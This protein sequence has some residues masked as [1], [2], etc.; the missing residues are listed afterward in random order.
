MKKFLILFG[1]LIFSTD[2]TLSQSI[3]NFKIS[4][5]TIEWQL[6]YSTDMTFDELYQEIS[7]LGIFEEINLNSE[8]CL[9][10][11]LAKF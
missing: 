10:M 4:N 11:Q 6:V 2:V 7:T 5:S 8:V 9:K 1:L 3:K